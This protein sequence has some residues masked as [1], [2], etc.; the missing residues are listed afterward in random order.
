MPEAVLRLET[1]IQLVW[2]GTRNLHLNLQ[3]RVFQTDVGRIYHHP[4]SS[5]N[6]SFAVKSYVSE[7]FAS[8]ESF[9]VLFRLEASSCLVLQKSIIFLSIRNLNRSLHPGLC[10]LF[11]SSH[12][13]ESPLL[14]FLHCMFSLITTISRKR[15]TRTQMMHFL[16]LQQNA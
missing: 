10:S 1:V 13:E 15:A 6:S 8:Y 9:Q 12:M 16:Q 3:P 2:V 4:S 7:G 11:E 5:R 14:Q